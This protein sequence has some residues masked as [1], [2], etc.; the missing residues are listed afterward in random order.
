MQFENEFFRKSLLSLGRSSLN[1]AQFYGHENEQ[2]ASNRVA[3]KI[4]G[5]SLRSGEGLTSI[6]SSLDIANISTPKSNNARRGSKFSGKSA[7]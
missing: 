1:T 3:K 5:L 4:G 6:V 2:F 7:D